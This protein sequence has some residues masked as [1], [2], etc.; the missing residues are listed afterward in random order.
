ME[1]VRNFPILINVPCICITRREGEYR[2]FLG[3]DVIVLDQGFNCPL[4]FV[5]PSAIQVGDELSS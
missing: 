4:S 2:E 5:A 1:V 3:T